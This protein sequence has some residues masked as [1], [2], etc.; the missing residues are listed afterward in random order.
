MAQRKLKPH[1]TAYGKLPAAK[2]RKEMEQLRQAYEEE[3]Q[4]MRPLFSEVKGLWRIHNMAS[5]MLSQQ[6]K[7]QKE[8][9]ATAR[10]Q[11]PSK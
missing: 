4:Q 10:N 6:R 11:E 9:R 3:Q 7:Q 8:P 1:F 5:S 2:W